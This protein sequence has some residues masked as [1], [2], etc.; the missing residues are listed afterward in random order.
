M[1]AREEYET[2][3]KVTLQCPKGYRARGPAATCGANGLFSSV[4]NTKCESKF[5]NSA[6]L[7]QEVQVRSLSKFLRRYQ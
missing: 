4:K 6:L 2:D 1:P 3:D 5:A 7:A